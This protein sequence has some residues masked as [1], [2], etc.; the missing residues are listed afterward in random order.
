MDTEPIKIYFFNKIGFS[1]IFSGEKC[2]FVAPKDVTFGTSR[3]HQAL[4]KGA[5]LNTAVFR[6]IEDALGWLDVTLDNV[7]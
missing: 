6:N 1:T 4:V 2:A 3:V 7:L 5:D